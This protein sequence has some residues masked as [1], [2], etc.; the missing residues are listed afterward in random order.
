LFWQIEKMPPL[1]KILTD[2][3]LWN[4]LMD[5]NSVYNDDRAT[6]ARLARRL[7]ESP[8][9]QGVYYVVRFPSGWRL[10]AFPW[11]DFGGLWHGDAWRRYVALDL[12]EARAQTATVA[13]EELRPWWKGFPRGRVARTGPG[14]YV[15]FHA[16]DLA[17]T[18]IMPERIAWTFE[19][20]N[21]TVKWWLTRTNSAI[22]S[23]RRR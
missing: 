13:A 12:A 9:K 10:Y 16:D 23:M 18:G 19:S 14:E 3:S 6:A 5:D 1:C 15:V 7:S 21:S 4:N 2:R 11:E 8:G 20:G 17:E 22:Q